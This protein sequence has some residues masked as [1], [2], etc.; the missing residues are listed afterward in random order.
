MGGVKM[1]R[2]GVASLCGVLLVAGCSNNSPTPSSSELNALRQE[3]ESL[4]SE[5]EILKDK[6]VQDDVGRL[7]KDADRIAF[8]RPGD[9]GYSTVRYDL[10][11]LTVE[12]ADVRP[13]ANGSKVSLRIGNPLASTVNGLKT[14]IEWGRVN[15]SGYADND[16]VKSRT[17]TFTESLRS[18][19]WTTIPLVLEGIPPTEL[20]FVRVKEVTHTGIRLA[21]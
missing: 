17:F 13:Y 14:T 8:L 1:L 7:L 15:E 3:F 4:K 10:G 5:V 20:G 6:Q 21:S 11:T 18:G 2:I 19:A 9:T 12:L 16:S